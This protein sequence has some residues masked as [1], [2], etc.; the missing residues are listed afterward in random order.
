MVG[1]YRFERKFMSPSERTASIGVWVLTALSSFVKR[2][3][4]ETIIK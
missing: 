2:V 3:P 1:T 4:R